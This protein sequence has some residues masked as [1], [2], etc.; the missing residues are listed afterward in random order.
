[1]SENS[2][3][4]KGGNFMLRLTGGRIEVRV[5]AIPRPFPK[6]VYATTIWPFVFYEPQVW[7]DKCVQAHERHHWISQIR[8]LVIPWLIIYF[9]LSIKYGGGRAHPFEKRAYEVQ[10]ECVQSSPKPA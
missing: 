5:P 3:L 4:T 1:M 6:G 10:D 9:L 2:R 7:D 8:W